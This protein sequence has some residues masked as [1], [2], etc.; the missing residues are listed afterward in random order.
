MGHVW[1]ALASLIQTKGQGHHSVFTDKKATREGQ[2]QGLEKSVPHVANAKEKG[3]FISSGCFTNLFHQLALALA[4][5]FLCLGQV[6]YVKKAV[7]GS[8]GWK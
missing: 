5:L 4:S 2:A 7:E 3:M 1:G 8:E 6:H